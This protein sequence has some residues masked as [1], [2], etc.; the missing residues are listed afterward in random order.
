MYS[1]CGLVFVLRS[2]GLVLAFDRFSKQQAYVLA[3]FFYGGTLCLVVVALYSS[4]FG[5]PLKSVDSSFSFLSEISCRSRKGIS[6]MNSASGS[7]IQTHCSQNMAEAAERGDGEESLAHPSYEL[8]LC[9]SHH[10]RATS[11]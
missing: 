2:K 8:R 4:W 1:R 3:K 10:R 11:D 6:R 9:A 5:W 7:G